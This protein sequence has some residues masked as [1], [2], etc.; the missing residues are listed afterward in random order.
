MVLKEKSGKL[1]LGCVLPS[2]LG[3]RTIWWRNRRSSRLLAEEL[4]LLRKRRRICEGNPLPR[5]RE[6]FP[7]HRRRRRR[8]RRRVVTGKGWRGGWLISARERDR[9]KA[10]G[11]ALKFLSSKGDAMLLPCTLVSRF[12]SSRFLFLVAPM[13]ECRW[14]LED[15][16][17]GEK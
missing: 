12:L 11:S 17:R 8:R 16:S 15:H 14:I 5:W 3:K 1:L 2:R 4:V 9:Q 10:T 13:L 6:I 7:R